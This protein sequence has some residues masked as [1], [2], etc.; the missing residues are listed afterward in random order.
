MFFLQGGCLAN[1]QSTQIEQKD[2]NITLEEQ[3]SLGETEEVSSQ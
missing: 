3:D 2:Q 1:S